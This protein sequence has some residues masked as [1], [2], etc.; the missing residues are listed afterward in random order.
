MGYNLSQ[1]VE[2]ARGGF[3]KFQS[4]AHYPSPIH[5]HATFPGH[6]KQSNPNQTRKKLIERFTVKINGVA[7]LKATHPR[8]ASSGDQRQYPLC[9]WG[10][11]P[12]SFPRFERRDHACIYLGR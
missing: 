3:G 12:P 7:K 5:R 6:G 4:P 11:M 8:R 9:F 1:Q 10:E 2:V